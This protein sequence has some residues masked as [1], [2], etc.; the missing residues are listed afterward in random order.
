[1]VC[2]YLSIPL[3]RLRLNVENKINIHTEIDILINPV[4]VIQQ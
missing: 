2:I 1:M 4:F 3:L